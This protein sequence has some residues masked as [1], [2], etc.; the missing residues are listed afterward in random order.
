M[1]RKMTKAEFDEECRDVIDDGLTEFE[2][3]MYYRFYLM[4]RQ[5]VRA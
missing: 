1:A 5:S 4:G 3:M 2:L